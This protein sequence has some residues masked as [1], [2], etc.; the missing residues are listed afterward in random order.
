MN[1]ANENGRSEIEDLLPWHAAGTLSAREAQSVEAALARDP[2]LKRRYE[3]VRE[4]LA[5][6]IHLNETLGAPS[7][8]AMT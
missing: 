6:T 2:E 7:A 1:T 8:R 4:E 3:L 5:Q